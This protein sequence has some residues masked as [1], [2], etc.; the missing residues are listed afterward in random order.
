MSRKSLIVISLTLA[1]AVLETG[2]DCNDVCWSQYQALMSANPSDMTYVYEYADC[3]R[4]CPL[5]EVHQSQ[6]GNI[7]SCETTCTQACADINLN[8]KNDAPTLSFCSTKVCKPICSSNSSFTYPVF[9]LSKSSSSS[10]ALGL[11]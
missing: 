8:V 2:A 10:P 5:S 11:K 7:N 3:L 9:R 1:V 4:E 6:P